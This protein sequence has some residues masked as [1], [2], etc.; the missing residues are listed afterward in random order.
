MKTLCCL[1]VKVRNVDCFS[2]VSGDG[3]I[4][5]SSIQTGRQVVSLSLVNI[6]KTM[7]FHKEFIHVL[8]SLFSANA[9]FQ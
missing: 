5:R 3:R 6:R 7:K 8:P 2:Q 1:D 4:K 9:N